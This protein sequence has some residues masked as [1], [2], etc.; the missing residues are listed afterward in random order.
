MNV[1]DEVFESGLRVNQVFRISWRCQ[2]AHRRLGPMEI[3]QI[4]DFYC[5]PIQSQRDGSQSLRKFDEIS[6]QN[7]AGYMVPVSRASFSLDKLSLK[8]LDFHP[9]QLINSLGAMTRKFVL[10]FSMSRIN[11]TYGKESHSKN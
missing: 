1:I 6:F 5:H 9:F 8:P 4:D 10:T 11:R 7:R 3:G 2:F